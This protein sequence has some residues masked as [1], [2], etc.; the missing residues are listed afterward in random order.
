MDSLVR[1][2]GADSGQP[3]RG[4]PGTTEARRRTDMS[5]RHPWSKLRE[6]ID[7]DPERRARVDAEAEQLR[8]AARLAEIRESM[9]VTQE[10]LARALDV[11]QANV[12]RIENQVDIQ[13]ST[14]R[15]YVEGLGGRLELA[16]V[17]PEVTVRLGNVAG[18]TRGSAK[19]RTRS[20]GRSPGSA[21]QR[22]TSVA[23]SLDW[24]HRRH[25]RSG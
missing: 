21:L 20:A 23:T 5:G 12:S 10:E 4:A 6:Q 13:L 11:S 9:R 7:A 3:L 15:R 8:V 22:R 25:S 1:G 16:V 2:D 17:F 14:L 18:A 24:P 19:R